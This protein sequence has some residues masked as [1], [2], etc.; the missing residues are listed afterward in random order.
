MASRTTSKAAKSGVTDV[1]QKAKAAY[2][3]G[4]AALS[5]IQTFS[6]GNVDAIAASGKILGGGLKSLGSDY[7]A[8]GRSA[9]ETFTADIKQLAASKSPA[10]FFKLQSTILGRNF[11]TAFDFQS[12]SAEAILKLAKESAAPISKR[13]GVAIE[14]FRKAA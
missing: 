6:K 5:D 13:V 2:A 8:E 7:V 4:A 11:G 14:A 1:K 12:K 10:D 9:A 3:K